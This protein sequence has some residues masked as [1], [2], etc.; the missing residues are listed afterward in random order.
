MDIEYWSLL[1]AFITAAIFV[2]G[3]LT[4][5]K[6]PMGQRDC[7]IKQSAALAM[8]P[9]FLFILFSAPYVTSLAV[10]YKQ[11]PSEKLQTEALEDNP[12]SDSTQDMRIAALED[13]I[14]NL[15]TDVYKLNVFYKGVCTILAAAGLVAI[16]I[17]LMSRQE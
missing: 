10:V 9:F 4:S 8:I 2:V 11:P 7:R 3:F 1:I 17:T 12:T 6:L 5:K 13:E 16:A 15:R 14:R